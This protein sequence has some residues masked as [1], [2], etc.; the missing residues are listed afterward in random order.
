MN[1][2]VRKKL[3][4]RKRRLEK[5]IDPT[6]LSGMGQ[7]M[8]TASNIHYELAD[9]AQGI[10]AGGIGLV[11][12]L[13]K[14]LKLDE[15]INQQVPLL[16]LHLPYHDSDHVLNIA[17]NILAGGTRLEHLELLRTNE[18]YLD[19][20]GAQRIP[21][22]TTAGDYCRR[23][24]PTDIFLLMRTFNR[25]RKKVWQEQPD[26]FFD[27]AILDADG[28]QVVTG[29]ECKEGIDINYKGEWG[30]HPLVVSLA[31]TREPLFIYNR[32]GN[33]PSHEQADFF[34]NEAI[35]LCRQAGFR[36]IT[37]R[38]DTD[39]SQTEHLDRWNDAGV[40]FVFGFDATPKLLEM[41]ENLPET[42]WKRLE[43]RPRY[44][45]KTQPRQRP[46]N[47]KQ[48][49]VERR[50]FENIRLAQEYVAEFDYQPTA[51]SRTYRMVVVWKD[52]EIRQG[53]RRLFDDARCFFYISNS[54]DPSATQIVLKAN[55]RCDHENDIEQFKNG[56]HALVAPLDTLESN[57]A[58][59]VIASLAWSLKAW[60]ALTLPVDGRW[61]EKH[62]QEKQQLIR[63]EFN[64]F[65]QA[66]INIP[67]QIVRTGRRIVYRLLSWNPWQGIFFR[68][69]D[70]LS[71]PLRC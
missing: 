59:M 8:F 47:V 3:E 37:L 31:N 70:Q 7:P 67:A 50:E 61:R 58:Y 14:R 55:G 53:Q 48:P 41:A 46:E 29:G 15:A 9:R 64:T 20:L 28:T 10:A 69:L 21:D 38:G 56:V 25:I 33:R 51:C 1:P 65:C 57:W 18:A 2:K 68:L 49:I 52:L 62:K 19:A 42:A 16:K 27:E 23:F 43:R 71:L 32:S 4:R 34:F 60:L 22:P 39:F 36:K 6:D 30:Y 17:Y 5:R 66:L 13:V 11:H 12:K 44:E 40:E 45:V 24:K 26:A 35:E 54:R 63:M